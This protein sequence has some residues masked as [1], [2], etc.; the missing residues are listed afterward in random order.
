MMLNPSHL[1]QLQQHHL[2]RPLQHHPQEQQHLQLHH[3]L[4]V[5]QLLLP[6]LLSPPGSA[7]AACVPVLAAAAPIVPAEYQAAML[8]GTQGQSAHPHP[9][10]QQ[11][12]HPLSLQVL[13]PLPQ[14]LVLH[15][16]HPHHQL[17]LLLLPLPLL[18]LLL[19]QAHPHPQLVLV[20]LLQQV[21]VA[22]CEV[23]A[24][25]ILEQLAPPLSTL[26]EELQ[27]MQCQSQ[28]PQLPPVARCPFHPPP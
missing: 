10:H 18:L 16:L 25:Q 14:P 11:Q 9:R 19:L 21:A 22:G 12:L 8:Q 13:L 23:V 26:Q 2:Q 27:G 5:V 3:P 20:L 24:I 15:H 6:L 4:Q 17:L 1:D 28:L 7:C